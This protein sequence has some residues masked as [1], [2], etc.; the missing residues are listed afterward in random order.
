VKPVYK[1]T[2]YSGHQVARRPVNV[3]RLNKTIDSVACTFLG[4]LCAQPFTALFA[5]E[6]FLGP[7]EF[8][9]FIEIGMG[10]GNTSMF[11]L[12]HCINKGAE[13][14]GYEKGKSAG[15]G[16]SAIKRLLNLAAHRRTQNFYNPSVMKSIRHMLQQPGVSIIFCDG[17]DKP[18]E[19]EQ[20][21]MALKPG[22][23]IAVHDWGRASFQEWL[24]EAIDDNGLVPVEPDRWDYLKSITRVW[25]CDRPA[26]ADGKFYAAVLPGHGR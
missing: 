23:Y 22:D 1:T 6:R 12:M 18:Y 5:W 24:Q 21:A 16:N 13:Y 3:K 25:R 4:G 14:V 17:I 7:L 19:F 11:F 2:P 20:F 26:I 8:S 15:K 10:Y 9:R